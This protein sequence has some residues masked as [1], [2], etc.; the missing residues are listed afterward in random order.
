[1][2]G[3]GH[4]I[5]TGRF[6]FRATFGPGEDTETLL[7]SA[8]FDDVFVAKYGSGSSCGNSRT[9][10][11]LGGCASPLP[12]LRLKVGKVFPIRLAPKQQLT[13]PFTVT[14][15]CINDGQRG[16]G[17]EDYSYTATVHHEAVDGTLDTYPPDNRCPREALGVAPN[18]D[19]SIKDK[20]CG[21]KKPD[22]TL[23]VDVLTD[24]HAR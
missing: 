3:D 12:D 19:G 20:G 23:G 22:Q 5:V 18:P 8:G 14:F 9:V 15:S 2:D 1:M 13:L 10:E 21:G 6:N 7:T 17:H 4:S 16:A 24:I 11:S